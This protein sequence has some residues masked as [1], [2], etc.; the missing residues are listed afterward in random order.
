MSFYRIYARVLLLLRPERRTVALLL[1]GTVGLVVAQFAEPVLFGHLIDRLTH[2]A[3]GGAPSFAALLP[4]V[5]AWA[6]FAVATIGAAVA[7]SLLADRLAHR[8]R[9][10]IMAQFFEHALTLPMTFHA[11][12]HSG[13]SLK[14]MIE[15]ANGMFAVYLSLFRE[16]I[17]ALMSLVVILPL[18]LW[19]NWRLGLLLLALVILSGVVATYVRH[20]T[21]TLQ[22]TVEAHN[23]EL[24]ERASDVLGNVP[25]IQS[26]TRVRQETG[27]MRDLS[28][29]LLEAQMPV[30]SWWTVAV[31]FGRTASTV[32]L[33]LIF[34]SGTALYLRGIG[35]IGGIVMFMNFANMLIGRLEQLVNFSNALFLQAAKLGEFFA[36]LDT[37]PHVAE[38]PQAKDP[39]HLAGRVAF[40]GV[41]FAYPPS[42]DGAPP[43]LAVRDLWFTAEPGETIALV[44][45]T[46]SGKS[47]TLALLH[48]TFDPTAGR[49]TIDGIDIRDMPLDAL[50]RNI[51]VVFQEPMLF[52]RSIAENLRIGKPD[53]SAAEIARAL[54]RA[55]AADFVR[56]QPHGLATRVGERGR[57]LSGGERQR[58]AIA[59]ALLKDPPI[60]IFDE[61]TA[62]LDADTERK[63]QLALNSATQGRTTFVIAH[64]L[65]TVR[66]AS[67]ILVLQ[68]GRV[69]ESGTFDELVARDGAFAVLAAAQFM[70]GAPRGAGAPA[71]AEA[72]S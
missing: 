32:T 17:S 38:K 21:E 35:T 27:V 57:Q 28:R 4:T 47:T 59:R 48:R 12:T 18:S 60:M 34:V 62:A 54:E 52:A 31:V 26:F 42:G 20:R 69:V 50:R 2:P 10:A 29:T 37:V 43:R 11:A 9:L 45:A 72:T 30:L 61:A 46:G 14:I 25:V 49:I 53:A 55:Q 51:G 44:G 16:N 39:G 13:R 23:S 67:R 33:L 5:A 24:A 1:L 71:L 40:E 3:G 36:V 64:R 22:G 7:V 65:A 68:N 8:R 66:H 63:L 19:L 6:G 70:A 56:D 58:V 41:S 15:S